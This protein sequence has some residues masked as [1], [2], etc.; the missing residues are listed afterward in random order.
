MTGAKVIWHLHCEIRI[1]VHDCLE[2]A[3]IE[4]KLAVAIIRWS[5]IQMTGHGGVEPPWW[6]SASFISLTPSH[7]RHVDC[8]RHYQM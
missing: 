3:D 6:L 5:V 8:T 2:K 4:K 7:L 1:Q